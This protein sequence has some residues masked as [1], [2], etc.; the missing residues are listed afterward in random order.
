MKYVIVDIPTVIPLQMSYMHHLG[1]SRIL[2]TKANARREDLRQLFC[3]ADFDVL[4]LLPH[5]IELVPDHAVDLVVNLDS[6]VEMS[7]AS[8]NYYIQHVSRI[9]N[10]FYSN[11]RKTREDGLLFEKLWPRWG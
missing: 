1:F 5:Q 8:I 10:A 4:F 6:M 3:C 11:N 9:G 7:E 2:S